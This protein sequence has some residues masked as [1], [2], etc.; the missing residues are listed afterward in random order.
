VGAQEPVF[1]S[2]PVPPDVSR[3]NTLSDNVAP[4]EVPLGAPGLSYRYVRTFG[5]STKAY[6]PDTQ[7]IN[8]PY[9]IGTD[10]TSLWVGELWGNRLLKYDREGNIQALLGQAGFAEDNDDTSFWE[11]ADVT[12][13]SD[14]NI[15]VVDSSNHRAAKLK[16]TGEKILELGVPWEWGTDNSHLGNPMSVA[17]DEQDNVYISDGAPWWNRRG[18][19]HRVQIFRSDGS[20][21]AT[22]GQTGICGEGNNQLCGP[23]HIAISGNQLYIADAG[24]DRVQ[25]FDIST[26]D[27]PTY[28]A[29]ISN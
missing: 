28:V 8:Y 13:D 23:R 29:T 9:G 21:R 4:A 6:L 7:H 19:N 25:I 5:E 10:G 1:P 20:Y 17:V 12:V 27:A 18:G 3:H 24:N 14:G 26:P 2:S 22:L 15:W 11:I 16:Q